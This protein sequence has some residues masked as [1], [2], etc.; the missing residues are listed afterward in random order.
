M[1]LVTDLVVLGTC[2]RLV[3]NELL[4]IYVGNGLLEMYVGN[5]LVGWAVFV[6][7]GGLL[8]LWLTN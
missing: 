4:E 6:I 5:E 3:G 7:N 2:Q 1:S 8:T